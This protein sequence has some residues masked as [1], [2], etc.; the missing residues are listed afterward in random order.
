MRRYLLDTNHAARLVTIS[1]PLRQKIFEHVGLGNEFYIAIPALTEILFGVSLL[2]RAVVNL[3]EWYRLEQILGVV[4]LTQQDARQAAYLQVE[5]RRRGRQI[6]TI[7]AQIAVIALRE[8]FTLLTTDRD[9]D[10][11]WALERENWVSG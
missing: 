2:P 11:I 3:E 4:A 10:A 9:F 7:D 1:Q 5:L 6:G 8:N